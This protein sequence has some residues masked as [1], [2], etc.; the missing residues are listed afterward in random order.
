VVKRQCIAPCTGKDC[1]DCTQIASAN[2]ETAV[3][4]DPAVGG[5]V[6]GVAVQKLLKIASTNYA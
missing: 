1:L 6:G 2:G 5:F 4:V 3:A